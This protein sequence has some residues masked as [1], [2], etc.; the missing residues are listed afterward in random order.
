MSSFSKRRQRRRAHGQH[1]LFPSPSRLPSEARFHLGPH[2]C[3]RSTPPRVRSPSHLHPGRLQPRSAVRGLLRCAARPPEGHR[4]KKN[5][6]GRGVGPEGFR[7]R[8]PNSSPSSRFGL[9]EGPRILAARKG[10]GWG[11]HH[12]G[13]PLRGPSIGVRLKCMRDTN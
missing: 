9:R 11:Y 7:S 13:R 6:L 4:E 5:H 2:H 3:R 1:R 12:F 8:V 10:Q